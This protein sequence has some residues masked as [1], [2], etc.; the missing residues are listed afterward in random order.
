MSNCLII[1]TSFA[2]NSF[3]DLFCGASDSKRIQCRVPRT[4]VLALNCLV[5]YLHVRVLAI[6]GNITH[7]VCQVAIRVITRRL[8][9]RFVADL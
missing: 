4:D 1:T 9:I 8:K 2:Y 7:Q 3:V 5:A 6:E